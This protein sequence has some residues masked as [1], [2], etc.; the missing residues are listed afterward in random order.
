MTMAMMG[1]L[2]VIVVRAE[3][4]RRVWGQSLY[5][6]GEQAKCP[7]CH[8]MVRFGPS[9]CYSMEAVLQYLVA[10]VAC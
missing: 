3:Y 5:L 7:S 6:Q 2:K 10:C 4:S 1:L 8:I 9:H